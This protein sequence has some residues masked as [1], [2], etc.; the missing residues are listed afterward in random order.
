MKLEV[1]ERKPPAR[2]ARKLNEHKMQKW[3]CME[4]CGFENK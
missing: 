1:D 2:Q 3:E 4:L